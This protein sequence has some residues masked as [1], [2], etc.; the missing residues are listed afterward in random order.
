[1]DDVVA[2]IDSASVCELG[3]LT[4]QHRKEALFV[5]KKVIRLPVPDANWIRIHWHSL[6]VAN[7]KNQA[8]QTHQSR[9]H[10]LEFP[11]HGP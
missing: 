3:T 10:L 11:H 4:A 5:M 8:M 6:T 1:M 2:L 9:G 7:M